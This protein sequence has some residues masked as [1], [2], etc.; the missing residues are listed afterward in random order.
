MQVA[1]LESEPFD[2]VLDA[3]D[4]ARWQNQEAAKAAKRR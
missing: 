4:E 1:W 2:R 3:Y